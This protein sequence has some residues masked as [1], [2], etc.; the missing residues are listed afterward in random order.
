MR[1]FNDFFIKIYLEKQ[2]LKLNFNVLPI[3]LLE[4]NKQFFHLLFTVK[5]IR[6][7]ER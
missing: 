6:F 1:I 3:P 7:Y 2:P 5:K 4:G